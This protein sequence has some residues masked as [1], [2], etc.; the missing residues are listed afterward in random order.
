MVYLFNPQYILEIKRFKIKFFLV[1]SCYILQQYDVDSPL[2]DFH[3]KLS[4]ALQINP[5]FH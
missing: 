4:Y 1:F 5:L 3:T 2:L